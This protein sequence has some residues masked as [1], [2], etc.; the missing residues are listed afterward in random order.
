MTQPSVLMVTFYW[1]EIRVFRCG[2]VSLSA[3]NGR[4]MH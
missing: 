2:R 3:E 4:L 1:T